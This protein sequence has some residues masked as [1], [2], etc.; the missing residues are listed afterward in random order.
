M[1]VRDSLKAARPV[2]TICGPI[3]DAASQYGCDGAQLV[4]GRLDVTHDFRER[5]GAGGVPSAG[6]TT[7]SR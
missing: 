3:E 5:L 2:G 7:L 1:E 6:C 4:V